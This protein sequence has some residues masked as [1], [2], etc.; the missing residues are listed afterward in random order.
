MA[1]I[2]KE[3]NMPTCCDDCEFCIKD[4][5]YDEAFCSASTYIQWHNLML[6]P[7]NH[8]HQD[9]PLIEIAKGAR[10]IDG[11]ELKENI[12]KWLPP[13]PCGVEEKEFP[14]E[15]DICVSTLMEIDEAPIIFEEKEE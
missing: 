7:H 11:K 13:D 9:C 2:V 4:W 12:I 10:L 14:F 1:L 5:D 8:R 3:L 6:V 15:T